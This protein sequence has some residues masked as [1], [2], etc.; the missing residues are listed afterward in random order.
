MYVVIYFIEGIQLTAYQ[1]LGTIHLSRPAIQRR[2]GSDP[3]EVAKVDAEP[4]PKLSVPE[5]STLRL[6]IFKRYSCCLTF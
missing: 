4:A 6:D 2:S 3:S 5:D 1:R